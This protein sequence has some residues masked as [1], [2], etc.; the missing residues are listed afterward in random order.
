LESQYAS[1]SGTVTKPV[2][3]ALALDGALVPFPQDQV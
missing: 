2:I 1:R 3:S